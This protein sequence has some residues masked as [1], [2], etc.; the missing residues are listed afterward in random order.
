MTRH[1]STYRQLDLAAARIIGD[2]APVADAI[3]AMG[4][5]VEHDQSRGSA[6]ARTLSRLLAPLPP[7]WHYRERAAQLLD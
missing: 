7:R 2:P 5:W 1:A 6:A 3:G 4:D